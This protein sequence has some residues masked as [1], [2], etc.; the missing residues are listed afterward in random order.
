MIRALCK[1]GRF[2]DALGLITDMEVK[3]LGPDKY[4]YD[5]RSAL[6]G[7]VRMKEAEYIV[8]KVLEM[9][10]FSQLSNE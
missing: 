5:A 6:A 1:A 8:S 2:E 3:K 9:S 10:K 7:A 4:T